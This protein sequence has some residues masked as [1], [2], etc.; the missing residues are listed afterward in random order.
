VSFPLRNVQEVPAT[1]Q[2]CHFSAH[3][4]VSVQRGSTSG[5]ARAKDVTSARALCWGTNTHSQQN[6]FTLHNGLVCSLEPELRKGITLG[7]RFAWCFFKVPKIIIAM[8]K[9]RGRDP[10]ARMI[11]DP[12]RV[13]RNVN[14]DD[15]DDSHIV[16]S[17]QNTTT[18]NTE[19]SWSGHHP[20]EFEHS[21]APLLSPVVPHHGGGPSF[22]EHEPHLADFQNSPV[23]LSTPTHAE[24]YKVLDP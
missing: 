10:P 17:I 7:Q 21:A 16:Q 8:S 14:H 12:S 22:K 3:T 13:I 4:N 1:L 9:E 23:I 18:E 20:R 6:N 15:E 5:A 2:S 24:E 11:R 19:S